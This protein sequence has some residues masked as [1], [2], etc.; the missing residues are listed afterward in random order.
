MTAEIPNLA[1]T[2]QLIKQAVSKL[3]LDLSGLTVLTEAASGPYAVTPVIAAMAGAKRVIAITADSSYAAADEVIRQT[4]SLESL[5]GLPQRV[6][7]FQE[8][9]LEL[10]AEADIVT[11]LGFVRPLD[12]KVVLSMRRGSVIPLMCEAWEY[13][14]QDLDLRACEQQGVHVFATNEDFPAIDVFAYSGWL[15]LKMLFEAG[16]EIHR[17]KVVVASGDKFGRVI[18]RRLQVNG[19]DVIRVD[20]LGREAIAGADAI[21]LADYARLDEI[22]GESGDVTAA[23]VSRFMPGGAVI[24]FAGRSDVRGL[25]ANGVRVYPD[26]ELPARR[27]GLTLAHLGARPV[28]DLHAAGLKVGELACRGVEADSAFSA[29]MQKM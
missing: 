2:A 19:V 25:S 11:N 5:C 12:A 8:R 24:C 21:I 17:S 7:I 6:E 23:D 18:E 9:R 29:L 14:P 26:R 13:R 4:R 1:R 27:M 22:I 15:A 20:R 3:E 28:V 16:I 10:F